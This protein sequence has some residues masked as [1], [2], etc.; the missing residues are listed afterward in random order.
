ME[1][2][3]PEDSRRQVL[4]LL[5]EDENLSRRALGRLLANQGYTTEAFGSAEEALEVLSG[6]HRR[7]EIAVVD[8]D[9]P[10]MS[11][12]ELAVHL[13]QKAPPIKTVLVTAADWDRVAPIAKGRSIRHLQKPIDFNDLLRTLS[14]P[15]P[16]N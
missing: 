14:E 12:A 1:T 9:L 11:G 5:V 8:V 6:D 16:A 2:Y 13:C 4:V 7:P 3:Y 10:G 15:Q